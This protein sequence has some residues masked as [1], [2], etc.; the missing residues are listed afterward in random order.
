MYCT[1]GGRQLLCACV[2]SDEK[3]YSASNVGQTN[4]AV[5]KKNKD[6][7]PDLLYVCLWWWVKEENIEE[8][9]AI[10]RMT[11]HW[12]T[13]HAQ[14]RQGSIPAAMA[15]WKASIDKGYLYAVAAV[16]T[17]DFGSV[18]TGPPLLVWTSEASSHI[19]CSQ[20][21]QV[22]FFSRRVQVKPYCYH[23]ASS[24]ETLR[25]WVYVLCS[26]NRW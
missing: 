26:Q 8:K 3:Q 10:C 21:H 2:F 23:T 5:A 12:K 1:C 11:Q 24:R 19:T 25:L 13:P 18:M 16:L 22:F 14:I 17:T 6:F 7:L 15:P 9:K 20:H 4:E